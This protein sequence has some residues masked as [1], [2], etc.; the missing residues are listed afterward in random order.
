V[1]RKASIRKTYDPALRPVVVQ[2]VVFFVAYAEVASGFAA[3][4]MGTTLVL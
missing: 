3:D 4:P 2:E 1:V